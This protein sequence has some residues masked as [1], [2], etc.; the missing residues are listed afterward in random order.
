METHTVIA[1]DALREVTCST[2]LGQ[3]FLHMAADVARHH[4]ERH[5]GTGYPDRLAGNAI[6]LA[7]RLVAVGDVYDALR[8]RRLYKPALP[9]RPPCKS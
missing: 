9:T 5:D 7:A 8:C 4:H 6:P 1:A 2:G 3:A